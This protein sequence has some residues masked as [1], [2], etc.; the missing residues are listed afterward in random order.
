[1]HMAETSLTGFGIITN[2]I[3]RFGESLEVERV[4][5]GLARA[6]ESGTRLGRRPVKPA[7]V[8]APR[9]QNESTARAAAT[10][11]LRERTAVRAADIAPTNQGA[12]GKPGKQACAPSQRA[13]MLK[14]YHVADPLVRLA[15]YPDSGD[16]LCRVRL[17]PAVNAPVND[18]MQR[19]LMTLP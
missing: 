17:W 18:K 9:P 19:H 7:V 8:L 2:L 4:N 1:M 13:S 11:A 10:R 6:R 14:A 12:P 3:D 15:D 16:G 5:A